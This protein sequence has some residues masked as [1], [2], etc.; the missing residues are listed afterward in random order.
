MSLS[1][2]PTAA[3]QAL[4]TT[5][6]DGSGVSRVRLLINEAE[7]RGGGRGA[8]MGSMGQG[9]SFCAHKGRHVEQGPFIVTLDAAALANGT[10]SEPVLLADVPAGTYR[11]AELELAPLGSDD[12][13]GGRGGPGGHMHGPPP[14]K[15]AV[16]L[17]AEFDD[18]KSSGATLLVD[19]S[20]N[21]APYTFSAAFEAEQETAASLTVTDGTQV[22][23]ALVIDAAGWFVDSAGSALD[24]T[25]AA[26][27][28]AI[29]ANMKKSLTIE[30]DHPHH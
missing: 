13:S 29:V 18:F 26:N 16:A 15:P 5:T 8:P 7:L 17:G 21:G 25:D 12:A 3:T 19:G 6:T 23:L 10:L 4:I 28:D 11:G 20:W 24:P 22:S 9:P 2:K 30:E 1:A 27:H 14:A